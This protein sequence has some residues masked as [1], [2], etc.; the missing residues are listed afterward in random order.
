VKML[1]VTLGALGKAMPGRIPAAGSGQGMIV[2]LATPNLLDGGQRVNVLQPLIGGSGARPSKDGFDGTD[3]TFAFL[4]NTPIEVLE[5]ENPVLVHHYG[6]RQDSAGPGRFRGGMGLDIEFET[7]LPK[8]R[9]TARAMERTRFAPWGTMGGLC[10]ATTAPCEIVSRNGTKRSVPKID[11]LEFEVGD[12]VRI[13][14]SGAGGFGDPRSRSAELIADDLSWGFISPEAAEKTYGAVLDPAGNVDIEKTRSNRVSQHDSQ[15]AVFEY[16]P[17]REEFEHL[18]PRV[19]H[20]EL[21]ERLASYPALLRGSIKNMVV[22]AFFDTG[23]AP[24]TMADLDTLWSNITKQL[25]A[26]NN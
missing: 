23:K 22:K 6:F 11:I 17:E 5:A 1:E 10:G 19:I 21:Q 8:T 14:T 9:L 7:I 16:G 2:V 26:M 4:R 20:D 3:Y 25:P 13:Q 12:V 15:T 24:A 18:W